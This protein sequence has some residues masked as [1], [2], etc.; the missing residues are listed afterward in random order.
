MFLAKRIWWL[1]SLFFFFCVMISARWLW[2][3]ITLCCCRHNS[4]KVKKL[5]SV[6]SR[7]FFLWQNTRQIAFWFFFFVKWKTSSN[8]LNIEEKNRRK[9]KFCCKWD[10]NMIPFW[11]NDGDLHINVIIIYVYK[12]EFYF[13][14][15]IR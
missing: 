10:L 7:T 13:S 3:I 4:L 6:N 8:F 9:K 12:N 14:K 2:F 15:L 5:F 11:K 1:F